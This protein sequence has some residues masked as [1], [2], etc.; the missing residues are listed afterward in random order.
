MR[1]AHPATPYQKSATKINNKKTVYFCYGQ[2]ERDY[3]QLKIAVVHFLQ[4]MFLS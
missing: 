4:N 1:E 2:Q 3:W